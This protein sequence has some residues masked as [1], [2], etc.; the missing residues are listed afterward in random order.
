MGAMF[1]RFGSFFWK[2]IEIMLVVKDYEQ[3]S[4]RAK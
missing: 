4:I 3:K 2:M 1:N